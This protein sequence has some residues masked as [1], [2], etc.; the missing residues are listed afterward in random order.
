M[1]LG[2][3]DEF[4]CSAV[5]LSCWREGGGKTERHNREQMSLS[6]VH[7]PE[8]P[9]TIRSEMRIWRS[10][11]ERI[12]TLNSIHLNC[13]NIWVSERLREREMRTRDNEGGEKEGPMIHKPTLCLEKF[14]FLS[15]T[16]RHIFSWTVSEFRLTCV[17]SERSFV[18]L[19]CKKLQDSPESIFFKRKNYSNKT[20]KRKR[21]NI[22]GTKM[23]P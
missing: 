16:C 17:V 11:C 15:N 22:Q 10:N 1:H 4:I 23:A 14:L 13:E 21:N 5:W 12:T 7:N 6:E 8:H 9:S 19:T 3:G 2:S 18:T 20:K